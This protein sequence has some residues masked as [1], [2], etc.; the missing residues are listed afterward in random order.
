MTAR[1]GDFFRTAF[2]GDFDAYCTHD[3]GSGGSIRDTQGYRFRAWKLDE[4]I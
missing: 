2:L 4:R 3:D 1:C